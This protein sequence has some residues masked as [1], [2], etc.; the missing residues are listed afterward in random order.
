MAPARDGTLLAYLGL[1][2]IRKSYLA[3]Q[4]LQ[5]PALSVT[6]RKAWTEVSLEVAGEGVGTRFSHPR[7][8][9]NVV[10][11]RALFF[12]LVLCQ[13]RTN[14]TILITLSID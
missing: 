5:L 13:I 7:D 8:I 4:I 14:Q 10:G 2:Q 3:K 1:T 11:A 9:L 6:V 12:S